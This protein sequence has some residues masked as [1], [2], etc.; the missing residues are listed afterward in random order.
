M[1]KIEG[2]LFGSPFLMF[3]F[4]AN[5]KIGFYDLHK[6]QDF[7]AKEIIIRTASI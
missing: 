7:S 2:E 1:N 4:Y 5:L 6:N 3:I